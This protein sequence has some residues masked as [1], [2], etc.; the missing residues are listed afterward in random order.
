MSTTLLDDLD[1]RGLVQ[2]STD[3][4]Q[5]AARL[6]AGPI[7]L[8]YG[9]DPT[10]DSLHIGNLIGLLVLRRFQDAGHRPVALAGGA[11]G[12]VGDPSGISEERNLLDAKTLDAN[13]A[14]IKTQMA[15]IL[16]FEEGGALLVD[17]RDWTA[18]VTLL[19]F[20]RNVGKHVTVN[21]MLA[22]ESVR[23]RLAGEQGISYTEFSYML[24]Q[25]HDYLWL[26]QHL[27][28]EL[29]IGGSDQWGNILSGIDLVRR[30][31]GQAIHGLSWPLITAPDGSKLGK[32]T[33]G[34]I[35]LDAARTSPYRFYQH[36][37]QTDDRQVREY[38]AKFT[39]LDIGAVDELAAE[40]AKAPERRRGQ[41]VLAGEVT[42][43]VH[44]AG[45][46]RAAEQASEILFGGSPVAAGG[47]A[48]AVV[49]AEVPT[50][51]LGSDE[52]LAAGIDLVP[53]LAEAGL[54]SSRGDARRSLEQ[55]A[56]WVNGDRAQPGRLIGKGDVL[57]GR[58]VVLRKGKKSYA[59]LV[60]DGS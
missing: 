20:L 35:W 44:G 27:G 33:G 31:R 47:D 12:M 58:Y 54:A 6:A 18:D 32:T 60:R 51:S 40:H 36:W 8:Y 52:N 22:R 3:R 19:D 42:E 57:H 24:L 55:G 30:V 26:N 14:A 59:V 50:A 48:L 21:Q 34:R 39:L 2:D 28:V 53:L 25:A 46:A 41:R 13:V 4:Q 17:N 23:A 56:V 45:A 7:S 15:H 29:Q 1:A 10:A 5:L 37:M 16:D 49:A 43:L 11:T 9:C 38:L